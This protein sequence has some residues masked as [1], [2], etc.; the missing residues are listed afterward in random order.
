MLWSLYEWKIWTVEYNLY[1]GHVGQVGPYEEH[2]LRL[3]IFYRADASE[4]SSPARSP[5][6]SVNGNGR[7]YEYLTKA[8]RS[9]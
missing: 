7:K 5:R 2:N 6:S 8:I 9:D 4:P 1:H 3:N